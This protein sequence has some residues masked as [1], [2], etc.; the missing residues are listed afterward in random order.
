MEMRKLQLPPT[1]WG[2]SEKT[3]RTQ[4]ELPPPSAAL[5]Q[6]SPANPTTQLNTYVRRK[7][8]VSREK[9]DF[10]A[11]GDLPSELPFQPQRGWIEPMGAIR[12]GTRHTR[13]AGVRRAQVC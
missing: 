12:S 1:F 9:S 8:H 3:N 5:L 7:E 11:A 4:N 2:N 6:P 10:G 13:A